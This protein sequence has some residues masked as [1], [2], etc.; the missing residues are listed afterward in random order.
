MTDHQRRCIKIWQILIARA[1]NRQTIP[2]RELA[3]FIDERGVFALT[4]GPY[5]QG[6]RAFCTDRGYPDLTV[7]VV[8]ART[9]RPSPEVLAGSQ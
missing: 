1:T 4:L 3:N 2:Y 5:W 8:L 7:L 9:G 6:I